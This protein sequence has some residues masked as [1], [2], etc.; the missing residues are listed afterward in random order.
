MRSS[1]L[2]LAFVIGCNAPSA[3]GSSPPVTENDAGVLQGPPGPQGP[4]GPE[5]PAGPAGSVGPAG[6][7]GPAGA[8]G[9]QGPAGATGPA[10][11]MG[12]QGPM[13]PTG[14]TGP[15]GPAG[16]QGPA[17]AQGATGATGPAGPAG[18]QGATGATGPAGPAGPGLYAYASSGALLGIFIGSGFFTTAASAFTAG[19]YIDKGEATIYY[20][21]ANCQ[22]SPYVSY[23]STATGQ[24][25]YIQNQI[26]WTGTVL[27]TPATNP[28]SAVSATV[29][30]Y[31]QAGTCT[32]FTP[33]SSVL[34]PCITFS[35]TGIAMNHTFPWTIKAQ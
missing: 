25:P 29:S 34:I 31:M 16:P 28:S 15:A 30:S 3:T 10:G 9:P 19:Y 23:V 7:A 35:G 8:T 12:P 2:L 20:S 18:P 26:F 21:S 24:T 33:G 14:L 27:V 32:N 1:M 22:G 13:G 17:G 4:A 5:G 6:P 11:A